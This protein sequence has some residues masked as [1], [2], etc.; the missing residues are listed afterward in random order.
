MAETPKCCWKTGQ[1][2][3]TSFSAQAAPIPRGWQHAEGSV[4][5]YIL[6]AFL[7]FTDTFFL[8]RAGVHEFGGLGNFTDSCYVLHH[9]V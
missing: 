6:E 8:L 5:I 3:G 2:P 9:P 1:Q 7:A 4:S